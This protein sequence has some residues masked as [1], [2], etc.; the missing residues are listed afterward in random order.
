MK[1]MKTIGLF[2]WRCFLL[3]GSAAFAAK[4]VK[5]TMN[6]VTA[7]GVG[8]SIGTITVKEKARTASPSSR[9]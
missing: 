4:S 7:E 5:V 2:P 6:A 8:K 3:G 9:S 1:T